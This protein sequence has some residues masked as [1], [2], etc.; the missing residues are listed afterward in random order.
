MIRF[1]PLPP[2]R[3]WNLTWFPAWGLALLAGATVLAVVSC[4]EYRSHSERIQLRDGSVALSS[5]GSDDTRKDISE[6]ADIAQAYS[7]TGDVQQFPSDYAEVHQVALTHL[8]QGQPISLAETAALL[9]IPDLQIPDPAASTPQAEHPVVTFRWIGDGESLDASD[10]AARAAQ[11][12]SQAGVASLAD[13]TQSLM[14]FDSRALGGD[15]DGRLSRSE[16]GVQGL[17]VAAVLGLKEGD[18]RLEAAV[19]DNQIALVHQ[20]KGKFAR[21]MAFRPDGATLANLPLDDL[22][23]EWCAFA[24]DLL[25]ARKSVAAVSDGGT[26]TEIPLDRVGRLLALYGVNLNRDLSKIS[27]FYD[28]KMSGGDANG[29]LNALEA[30]QLAADARHASRFMAAMA[31][32]EGAG[33]GATAASIPPGLVSDALIKNSPLVAQLFR[34]FPETG[35]CVFLSRQD[36]HDYSLSGAVLR[37]SYFERLAGFDRA[38]R[39]GNQDGKLDVAE[40]TLALTYVGTL[41]ALFVRYD[42]NHDSKMSKDEAKAIL[43]EVGIDDPRAVDAFFAD[44]IKPQLNF[45]DGFHV[46]IATAAGVDFLRPYEFYRRMEKVLANYF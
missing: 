2:R 13:L 45:W 17:V 34:I 20:L 1:L 7:S 14:A 11:T 12:F 36:C 29:K 23:A 40:L 10:L 6:L 25:R 26:G 43:K 27:K 33:T 32:A 28:S 18:L 37:T 15:G 19:P 38:D 39:G 21:Q 4:G 31:A 44:V 42:V 8:L 16:S 35:P 46:F 30:F 41:D 9:L 24:L 5:T 3:P 22:R